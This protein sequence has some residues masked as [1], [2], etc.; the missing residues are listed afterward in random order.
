[1]TYLSARSAND[2]D[3]LFV[4]VTQPSLKAVRKP[5]KNKS[6]SNT[7]LAKPSEKTFLL[8]NTSNVSLQQ[9]LRRSFMNTGYFRFDG[10]RRD[11]TFKQS[12]DT[13]E[14]VLEIHSREAEKAARDTWANMKN[15]MSDACW[16]D[17]E[18]FAI[19]T[20]KKSK[21]LSITIASNKLLKTAI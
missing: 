5:S 15:L 14:V 13:L 2:L 18:H 1:M 8:S 16:G 9:K 17:T 11:I 6:T 20:D 19:T 4:G 3:A 21:T 7:R 12:G 10:N